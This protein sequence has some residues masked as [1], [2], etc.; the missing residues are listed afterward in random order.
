[1]T[2][3]GRLAVSRR[4][5]LPQDPERAGASQGGESPAFWC[6]PSLQAGPRGEHRPSLAFGARSGGAGQAGAGRIHFAHMYSSQSLAQIFSEQTAP[7][8]LAVFRENLV[9]VVARNGSL[10]GC[11]A[12]RMPG[13]FCL[14]FA[15]LTDPRLRGIVLAR[16]FFSVVPF[17]CLLATTGAKPRE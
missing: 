3:G 14:A 12:R 17:C 8:A 16:R 5:A 15:W 11:V 2:V 6:R 10:R 4:T 13:A 1:M 9:M 7:P